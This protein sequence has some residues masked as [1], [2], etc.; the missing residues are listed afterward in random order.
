MKTVKITGPRQACVVE[1]PEPEPIK[2][3][4]KVK[5]MSAPMC[6]EVK[7]FV[8]GD[9][10]HGYGHEAVGEVV[11]VAQPCC[12]KPGDRVV[13]QPATPCGVCD[14]CLSGYYIHCEH[15]I[16][17]EAFAGT[18]HG[19]W[20]MSQYVLTADWQCSRIPDDVSYD[21]ASLTLCALGPSFGGFEIMKVDAHDTVLVTGLGPVGLGAI[22]NAVYRGARVIG[23]DAHPWR[24]ALARELGADAVIDPTDPNAVEAIKKANDHQGVDKAL[25]CSGIVAAH[26][27]CMDA[28]KRLGHVAFVGQC[29]EETPVC[30]SKDLLWKGLHLHGSW[31]YKLGD[32]PKVL[33]VATRSPHAPKLISHCFS[34]DQIQEAWETQVKGNCAKVILHPW[35]P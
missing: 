21:I 14:Y 13:V 2:D 15:F 22:V 6:T 11:A 16:D 17:Y 20:A 33:Q 5:V 12:V 28:T 24:A 29:H 32:F 26:R 31:H 18:P 23:V 7:G 19:Q 3:W 10:G 4:V 8:K 27:L 35:G 34:M 25:D 30:I 9:A 1:V